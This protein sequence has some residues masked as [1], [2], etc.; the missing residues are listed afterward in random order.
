VPTALLTEAAAAAADFGAAAHA[1]DAAAA[2]AFG[3]NRTDLRIIGLLQQ[4]GM[5]SAGRL[6]ALAGLSPAATTT[7]IQRLI[8]AGHL[9]RTV[10]G[11]DRRRAV[12]TLT[13][14]AAGLL[15]DIYSPIGEAGRLELSRYSPDQLTLITDFLRRGE[16]LQLGQAE[17]IRDL[18]VPGSGRAEASR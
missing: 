17:R 12:V 4:A 1:V 8:A 16:R 18:A 10:D 6:S 14:S 9:T 15:S 3:V 13:D 7:A 11:K 2:A 5:L